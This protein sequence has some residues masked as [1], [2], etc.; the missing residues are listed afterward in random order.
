MMVA[1]DPRTA[2]GFC[3]V[4]AVLAAG[5]A[6]LSELNHESGSASLTWTMIS[7]FVVVMAFG[8]F[9]IYSDRESNLRGSIVV[10]SEDVP[11]ALQD[12]ISYGVLPGLVL[13]LINYLFFFRYR[14][15]PFVV[16]RIREME[17]VYD[18][19]II[20][21][22]SAFS[23]EV[24]YHLF[25]MSCLLYVFQQLYKKIRPTWPFLVSVLPSAMALVLSSMLFALAHNIYGFT[26]AL[27]GGLLLGA[28]YLRSGIES[29]IAAHFGV[30]FLFVSAVYLMR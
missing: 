8:T 6:V 23:E 17:S 26:A 5:V 29:A 27:L 20:S 11:S 16:P 12:L 22:D 25:I 9:G 13:G 15:S 4:L 30:N 24:I 1:M 2:F 19:F 21:L 10:T 18:S 3:A 7:L 28:I 14:Y